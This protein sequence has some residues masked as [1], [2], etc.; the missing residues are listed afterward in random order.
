MPKTTHSIHNSYQP[1]TVEAQKQIILDH[2]PYIKRIVNRISARLPS[3]I[4][5]QDL[6]HA[7]IIGLITAI[8]RYDPNKNCSFLTYA[9]FIIK[10]AVLGELRSRD[11]LSRSIRKK[12]RELEQITL[13]LE[14]KLGRC[15]EDEEIAHALGIDLQTLYDIQRM[16][17]VSF[18]SL[19][20]IGLS[21]S[22]QQTQIFD[23]LMNSSSTDAH[24]LICLKEVQQAIAY[25]INSL[26]KKE[27]LVI[28]LYYWDEL[29]MKEI[30][31]VL[32]I[33]ESRV[34]QIHAGA[35]LRLRTKL[36]KRKFQSFDLS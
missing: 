36:L 8:E 14:Q 19:E 10:G 2:L 17:A 25:S 1:H 32:D 18:V 26:P 27:Q 30:G 16:A 34:S 6:I 31:R 3:S 5:T 15:P 23:M 35:L 12:I 29:T 4:E 28:S 22:K 11:Y 20:D 13:Q 33:S 9:S 21:A 24:Q 7:G